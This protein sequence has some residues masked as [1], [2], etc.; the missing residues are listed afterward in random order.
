MADRLSEGEVRATLAAM[1]E[2]WRRADGAGFAADF[3]DDADF[4]NILG[5]AFHGRDQI[6]AQHQLIYDTI[7]KDSQA[8]FELSALRALAE[9]VATAQIAATLDAP[10]GPRPGIT[11][12]LATAT[13]VR[14]DGSWKIAAFHN[15]VVAPP[16]A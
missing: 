8:Q 4:V 12:T 11:K 9:G 13:F 5:M 15:T 2:A 3:T 10:G 16:R 1:S 6:A 7:Y 14:A